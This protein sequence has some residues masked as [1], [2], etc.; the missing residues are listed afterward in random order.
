[1]HKRKKKIAAEPLPTMPFL[2]MD[3]NER[4]LWLAR[5]GKS[6]V[7]TEDDVKQKDGDN[8]RREVDSWEDEDDE[9]LPL[10]VR[11]KPRTKTQG[12]Q[13]QSTDT[14]IVGDDSDIEELLAACDAR[15]SRMFGS[16]SSFFASICDWYDDKG[17]L[18]IKQ[19]E[20]LVTLHDRLVGGIY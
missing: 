8:L 19:Y 5:R 14:W 15:Q 4:E 3:R 12:V 6:K 9:D 7:F 10:P 1:M 18:T 11:R 2:G 16:Q 20:A 17:G 13:R